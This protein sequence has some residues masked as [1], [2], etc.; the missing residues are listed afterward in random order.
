MKRVMRIV[1]A[2]V[3]SVALLFA[4]VPLLGGGVGAPASMTSSS[5]VVY[6]AGD[7]ESDEGDVSEA[8]S[9]FVE[10]M[11]NLTGK[12]EDLSK[13][14]KLLEHLDSL[15]SVV[16]GG[17]AILEVMGVIEDPTTAA[18]SQILNE[19]VAIQDKLNDMDKELK[20]IISDL[21]KLEKEVKENQRN[22][23]AFGY[24]DRWNSLETG[25]LAALKK[26]V[27][28]YQAIIDNAKEDWLKETTHE[29]VRVLYAKGAGGELTHVYS[30]NSYGEGVPDKAETGEKI[31]KEEC[32]GLPSASMPK[33]DD[34][35][36]DPDEYIEKVTARTEAAFISA[37][38]SGTLAWSQKYKDQWSKSSQE[39]KKKIAA[40]YAPEIVES[41]IHDISREGMSEKDSHK[42]AADLKGTLEEYCSEVVKS[43]YGLDAM[44]QAYYNTHGLEGELKDAINKT[45]DYVIA[46]T[47]FYGTFVLNCLG[48]DNKYSKEKDLKPLQNTWAKTMNKLT[49]MKKG[50][51]T[52]HD[53][54]CYVTNTLLGYEELS[55]ESSMMVKYVIGIWWF[56]KDPKRYEKFDD[57]QW[58]LMT[59]GGKEADI[60]LLGDVDSQIL[61]H[62]FTRQSAVKDAPNTYAKYLSAYKVGI[63]NNF[64][65]KLMTTYHGGTV[66][67]LSD[68]IKMKGKNI[69]GDFFKTDNDYN[70]YTG[71]DKD[72]IV[73]HDKV[74]YN[75]ISS[76]NGNAGDN[77]VLTARAIYGQSKKTWIVDEAHMFL[78]AAG[79]SYD[80][81]KTNYYDG[82]KGVEVT[83]NLKTPVHVVK[84]DALKSV[85]AANSSSPLSTFRKDHANLK[86]EN[87]SKTGKSTQTAK[88]DWNKDIDNLDLY[89]KD[90]KK[91]DKGIKSAVENVAANTKIGGK[92]VKLT[93]K[94]EK[95]IAAKVRKVIFEMQDEAKS[96]NA[97]KYTDVF[98]ID[99]DEETKLKLAAKVLPSVYLNKK[100]ACKISADNIK[101]MAEYEPAFM[102]KYEKNNKEV[103]GVVEPAYEIN[104]LLVI[105]DST[106]K[107]FK[108]FKID[109]DVMKAMKL[110]M[111]VK[112]PVSFAKGNQLEV[113]HYDNYGKNKVLDKAKKNV[114]GS[115]KDKYVEMTVDSCS[116]FEMRGTG[117]EEKAN[118]AATGDDF[119]VVLMII[120]LIVSGSVAMITV[121]RRQK[122]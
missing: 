5:S 4:Y 2:M 49:A 23:L 56:F 11:E 29:G 60:A 14:A 107:Q 68:G 81:K 95:N 59:S 22:N 86:S 53:N 120:L 75:Y 73:L 87:N 33:T 93:D 109:N 104:P 47:G 61:Y 10:A 28:E 9:S 63:P 66:F 3:L 50:A 8:I 74:T 46:T 88:A 77:E 112:I 71:N 18:L 76:D 26:S 64:K 12:T 70:I 45:C 82:S 113:V 121:R 69:I 94:G 57:T 36:Y 102:L 21:K 85:A 91:L 114:K 16:S 31:E 42:W 62:L 13:L 105:W 67:A 116:L 38:D 101:T 17:I 80:E 35:K 103:D 43:Q 48:Q 92:K 122:R 24:Q 98:G 44:L 27:G 118:A 117:I 78:K 54:F 90:D 72:C 30:N 108:T 79:V 39:E 84:Q 15:T 40:T 110:S 19:V 111:N 96:N 99:D 106:L 115:G 119:N 37:A 58:K 41:V 25:S 1:I 6:A 7:N 89:E 65:D 20:D 34:M 55:V 100:G 83:A 97:I 51:L 32:I 52:G